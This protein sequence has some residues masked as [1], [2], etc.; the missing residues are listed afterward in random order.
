MALPLTKQQRDDVF[1]EYMRWLSRNEHRLP[2]SIS[3]KATLRQAVD[4]MDDRLLLGLGPLDSALAEPRKS[5]MTQAQKDQ[6]WS[7]VA[8]RRLAVSEVR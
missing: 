5:D 1:A 3:I 7:D 8:A 4:E 6:L 2:A